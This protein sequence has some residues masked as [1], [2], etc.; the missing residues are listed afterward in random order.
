MIPMFRPSSDVSNVY[1]CKDSV[2]MRKSIN[3]LSILVQD[4]L[5]LN[6]FSPS[7]FVFIHRKKDK[8]K[9]LYWENNGFCLWYKRLE[10]DRFHWPKQLNEDQ[11]TLTGQELNWLLDGYD[12][13]QMK[14]HEKLTYHT[15]S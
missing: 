5:S 9:I 4:A 14:K 15:V 8:L 13:N 11:P 6:P 2:D 10:K 12:L 7:L 1:L 3:G